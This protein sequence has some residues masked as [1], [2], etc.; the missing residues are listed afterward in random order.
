[1]K[2]VFT[3]IVLFN[4]LNIND[5]YAADAGVERCQAALSKRQYTQAI[6]AAEQSPGVPQAW[7][8]KGRAQAALQQMPQAQTSLQQ[9]ISLKPTG[10]D[11]ASAYML[12]GNV[13]QAQ[14]QTDAALASYQQ[15]MD[16]AK[17]EK[18]NRYVMVA[19]NLIGEAR[20]AANQ[21]PE[22]LTEFQAGEKL[23]MNDNER[24]DSFEHE[25]LTYHQMHQLDKA[26]EYQLKAVLMQKRAGTPDQYAEA[27]L[28]LG[29]WF[30]E[31]KDYPGAE[32]TY[33]RLM[34]YAQENGGVFYEAKTAIYWAQAKQL[35]GD[36]AG[37]EQLIKQ[38]KTIA[39]K[40]KDPELDA[41]LS[42]VQS[43]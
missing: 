22:A 21:Y 27:S 18:M 6:Q 12:L 32:K 33:Q 4:L 39:S 7:M 29:Q 3:L 2:S 41:L 37:A 34:Q 14:Q 15:A 8:C 16:V 35:Q 30:V 24:A 17:T 36:T 38:A 40:Y 26:V 42:K 31:Q 5:L 9:A 25:A 11:L 1:M 20:L 23:A 10:L 28:T 43:N 19:H 13:Q